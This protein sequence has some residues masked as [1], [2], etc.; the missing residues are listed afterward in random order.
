M[1]KE[2][3]LQEPRKFFKVDIEFIRKLDDILMK[4][5]VAKKYR[6]QIIKDFIKLIKESITE[7]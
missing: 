2:K 1:K 7:I 6:K 4:A 5:F 3:S